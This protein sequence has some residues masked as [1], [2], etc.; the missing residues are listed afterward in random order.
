MIGRALRGPRA[1]GN[2]EA[3]IV[4][5]R[6]EWTN[7]TDLLEPPEVLDLSITRVE[8]DRRRPGRVGDPWEL[9]EIED[10]DGQE[11]PAAVQAEAERTLRE[12]Q[13]FLDQVQ[14][15][16]VLHPAVR[17]SVSR[18]AGW[19]QL[20]DRTISVFEHQLPGFETLLDDS[21]YDL[22]GFALLSAFDDLPPPHP[23][24][25]VLR[26]FVE[27]ARTFGEPE[28]HAFNDRSLPLVVAQE[29]STGSWTEPEVEAHV[30]NAWSGGAVRLQM[31]LLEFEEAVDT[32]RRRLRRRH[33]N[34]TSGLDPEDVNPVEH[35]PNLLKLRRADRDLKP[36]LA[37]VVKWMDESIPHLSERLRPLPKIAWTRRPIGSMLGYWTLRTHGRAKGTAEIRI[38]ALLNTTKANVSDD[39][40]RYLVYH[41]LL[42]HVLSTRGHDVGFRNYEAK[43][44][45]AAALDAAFD[46]LHE[47]CD[48][49]PA[50][51]R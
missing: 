7:L 22:R 51:Y 30:R 10:A 40:L 28:F 8:R 3:H 17:L 29:L 2:A 49:N 21:Y 15:N 47:R 14:R 32:E 48:T 20:S 12:N 41:E 44:P 50:S 9:P 45:D 1:N 24:Q 26:A 37:D 36:I 42:H 39:M 5:V 35:E 27:H 4:N 13:L 11:L 23:S 31:S 33:R 43:W 46:T 34:E 19:Y 25:R 38:N 16:Q 6:D 18:L